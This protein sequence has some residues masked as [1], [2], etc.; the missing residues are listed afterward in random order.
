MRNRGSRAWISRSTTS[1]ASISVTGKSDRP[2]T[3][4]GGRARTDA[5]NDRSASRVTSQEMQVCKHG[6]SIRN[7]R[8]VRC[9]AN[10]MPAAASLAPDRSNQAI[11][12]CNSQK[13]VQNE[14]RTSCRRIGRPSQNDKTR[15]ALYRF[16]HGSRVRQQANGDLADSAITSVLHRDERSELAPRPGRAS[17]MSR[18]LLRYSQYQ[19]LSIRGRCFRLENSS[20]S[21]MLSDRVISAVVTFRLLRHGVRVR[22]SRSTNDEHGDPPCPA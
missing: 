9:K 4:T 19:T 16:A 7:N 8:D 11:T 13:Y 2:M 3:R 21:L 5:A 1:T 20:R 14:L 22:P 12:E 18:F 10:P 15:V 6:S 17:R